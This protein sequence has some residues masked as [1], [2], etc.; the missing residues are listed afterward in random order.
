MTTTVIMGRI[1]AT[2]VVVI[3]F[4]ALVK[5][6]ALLARRRVI[7]QSAE[8]PGLRMNKRSSDPTLLYFWSDGCA[9][10]APQERQIEQA[11]QTLAHSGRSLTVVK[12]NALEEEKLASSLNVMTVPTTVLLDTEGNVSA[13]NP[14]LTPMRKLVEQFETIG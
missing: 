11:K 5:S 1:L 7:A 8:V 6:I 4:T 12:L 10:C 2:L 3:V 9:Q 14:G 13:W